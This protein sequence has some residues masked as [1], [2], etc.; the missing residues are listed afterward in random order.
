MSLLPLTDARH[1]HNADVPDAAPA[2]G[3][4]AAVRATVHGKFLEAAGEKFLL[5]GATYG[6][7]APGEDGTP[8][9]P[10]ASERDFAAMRAHG[11]TTLRTYT[12]PP[13]WLLD[14]AQAQGLRVLAGV[15]W[16]QHVAFLSDRR[17]VADVTARV[18]AEV[19]AV[20]GHPALLGWTVGNEIPAPVVRWHGRRPTEAFLRRLHDVVKTEDPGALVTYVNYPT[21]EYLDLSFLD[22]VC[23]N[24]FLEQRAP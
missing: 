21:T 10:G 6:P 1:S 13:R 17:R 9:D 5:R 4:D 11:F 16:E 20:A 18:A 8:Y 15:A 23:F 12:A 7:F 14:S 2:P 24:V 3:C 19:R 22:L